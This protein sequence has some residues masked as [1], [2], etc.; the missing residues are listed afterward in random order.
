MYQED[1][2]KERKRYREEFHRSAEAAKKCPQKTV[3]IKGGK[4]LT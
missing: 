1:T 4:T 2:Y 3:V